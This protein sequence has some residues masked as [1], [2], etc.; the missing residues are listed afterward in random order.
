MTPQEDSQLMGQQ[1]TSLIGRRDEIAAVREKILRD[2][3]RLVTLFGVAGV[4]KTR[5]AV[6]VADE[7]KKDFV[8][9]TF[10][11]LTPLARSSQVLPAIARA[12]GVMESNPGPL[13]ERLAQSIG[14]R[15]TLLIVDN[16]EHVLEAVSELSYLL[17]ACS[18]LKVL[19]TSREILRLKWEW[20]FPVTPLPLPDIVSL[21]ALD[22]LA[23]V[24]SV[25]LFVQRAQARKAAFKLTTENAPAVAELCV[26]LD[27]LPLAIELAAAQ[28]ALMGPKDLL[29]HQA[30]RMQLMTGSTRDAPARHQTLR[31]A[32]DWS[33]DLLTTKE[34]KL[35]QRLSVFF[36]GWTLQTAEK[37]CSGDGL[38]ESE[39]LALLR[40]LVDHSLVVA[41]EET[42]S[43]IRYRFLETLREYS[44]RR[45]QETG[46]EIYF[47]RRH[48]NWYMTWAEGNEPKMW[49]PGMPDWLSQLD[50]EFGNIQ[51]GL[52]WSLTHSGE[53]ASGMRLF[54]AIE[55]YMEVRGVHFTYGQN[56][57]TEFLSLETDHT[58]ARERTLEI[59]AV[60]ARNHGDLAKSRLLA[61]EC[62]ALARELGDTLIAVSGLG[63]LGSLSL[64]ENDPQRAIA[65]F[66]EGAKEARSCA[67]QEPRPLYMN[68]VF[69]GHVFC[70]QGDYQHS[71][72]VLEEALSSVR[73]Q[74]D[75][76]YHCFILSALGQS[77]LGLG[78]I[79]RAE[80]LVLEGL[81]ISQT[82]DYTEAIIFALDCLGEAAW[83]RGEGHRAIR[84]FGSA[85][86]ER[87]RAGIINWHPD[88]KYSKIVTE[89][90]QETI[91][92]T[93]RIAR[94]LS[95]KE[96]VAWALSRE[97]K[98]TSSLDPHNL[99]AP[100]SLSELL[101]P[102]EW[103]IAEAI[104]WGL[105]NR[106]IAA[107][108]YVSTRTVDAHVRHILNKL[109]LNSRSQV[110][111]W[112]TANH[113][114]SFPNSKPD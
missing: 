109:E 58:L 65:L 12:C 49:G 32:I 99:R 52:Q 107:K 63:F 87:S 84:L 31:A 73:Q 48:L 27:G 89:L 67:E 66:E 72:S 113:T 70:L 21:P 55:R 28:M 86:A 33:Y 17:G 22:S 43:E 97:Y 74:G 102:R 78:D 57:A 8:Q 69:L 110:A 24:P 44:R 81:R 38:E 7:L 2:D 16:C 85:A 25:A 18:G 112:F 11:D 114:H 29:R 45:L 13:Q 46:K 111:A 19:A 105:S 56:V 104:T 62:K 98:T 6:A 68:L 20:V 3:V 93:Q 83:L 42:D 59:A 41:G 60:L 82:L 26:R 91:L 101:S 1:P 54:A 61:A 15:R 103:E 64:A 100:N 71:I 80:A 4:G 75:P 39:M 37:V 40:H 35:F 50:S 10:V 51:G 76:E 9:V 14:V 34:Q 96:S 30:Q 106:D 88:P 79:N 53:A 23:R 108:F 90:G 5:L 47:Q 36:T 77:L 94:E 95:S 92:N